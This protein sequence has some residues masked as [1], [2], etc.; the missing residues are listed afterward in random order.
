MTNKEMIEKLQK[1]NPDREVYI[2]QGDGDDCLVAH[3][4]K[5]YTLLDN[6]DFETEI[7]AVLILFE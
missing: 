4:V 3:T 5:E 2:Q 7:P 1:L 6:R